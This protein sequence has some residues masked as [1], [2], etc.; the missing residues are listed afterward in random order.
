VGSQI[1]GSI[2]GSKPIWSVSKKERGLLRQPPVCYRVLGLKHTKEK[3]MKT[4]DLAKMLLE[5]P[6]IEV[7]VMAAPGVTAYIQGI[8]EVKTGLYPAPSWHKEAKAMRNVVVLMASAE[9]LNEN[10]EI[11]I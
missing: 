2:K 1:V 6:D 10:E 9:T 11:S 3:K 4:H 8:E 5:G 7:A